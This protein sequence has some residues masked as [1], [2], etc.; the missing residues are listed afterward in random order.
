[1]LAPV[2]NSVCLQVWSWNSWRVGISL[3][4]FLPEAGFVSFYYWR[5]WDAII[6]CTYGVAEHETQHITYQ[7]CDALAV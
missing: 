2:H 6:K 7:M 1:M 4:I 5:L 3:N